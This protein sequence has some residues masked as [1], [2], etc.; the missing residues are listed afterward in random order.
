MLYK[1]YVTTQKEM[2]Y[3]RPYFVV[4]SRGMTWQQVPLMMTA[5]VRLCPSQYC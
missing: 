2:W 1:F 4:R 3:C 5:M